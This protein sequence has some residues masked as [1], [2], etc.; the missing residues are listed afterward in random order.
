MQVGRVRRLIPR[1][2][3]YQKLLVLFEE[4]LVTLL[5]D[6]FLSIKLVKAKISI[7]CNTGV[8]CPFMSWR[9][10]NWKSWL[11]TNPQVWER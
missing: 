4:V 1:I 2:A 6:S 5:K 10:I 3:K 9:G 7:L 8:G 11:C